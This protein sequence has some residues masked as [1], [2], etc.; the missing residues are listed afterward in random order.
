MDASRVVGVAPRV[1][2]ERSFCFFS[3]VYEL[4]LQMLVR[5]FAFGHETP[6]QRQIL[7]HI[8]VVTPIPPGCA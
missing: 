4:V 5:D 8:E 3:A 1:S 6:E 7:I 2:P